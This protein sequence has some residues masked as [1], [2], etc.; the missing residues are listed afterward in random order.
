MRGG[1][2]LT[3]GPQT[4]I[5]VLDRA[6]AA[7]PHGVALVAGGL[8]VSYAQYAHAAD[9]L[10]ADLAEHAGG[11]VALVLRNSLA[12]PIA[13]MACARAGAIAMPLNPDY[14]AHELAPIFADA[15]PP[16]ILADADIVPTVAAAAGP[17]TRVRPV[18]PACI[19]ASFDEPAPTRLPPSPDP[20]ATGLLMFTGGTTGRPKGV[21]LSHRATAINMAQFA[22]RVGGRAD[23]VIA[24]AMPLYHA[25]GMAIGVHFAA[26]HAATLVILPRYRPDWLLDAVE[27][28]RA[29][30]LPAGP[31]IFQSLLGYAGLTRERVTS[32][33]LCLSG[34]AP[35][36]A[37]T[38]SRWEELT[39]APIYEGYGMTEAGPCLAFNGPGLPRKLGGTGTA[40]P[41]TEIA[42]VDPATR[43]PL[44]V[45]TQGEVR[46]R[47][48]QLMQ[49]YWHRA[50]ETAAA[51]DADGWLYT[52]DIGRI[53]SDGQLFIEDRLKDMVIVG[54]YNVYP[55]EVDEV[56][57]THPHVAE[58][59][60]VGA[61]CA[62]KGE[63]II[64]FAAP[65]D[66]QAL[67]A[68]A[69][70]A[71]CEARLVRYKRPAEYR[72]VERLPRTPVNKV[73]KPALR[74]L[75]RQGG[76]TAA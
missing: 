38:L 32:V 10:A 44:P 14:T 23:D 37:A 17:G 36:S 49:G 58:A 74:A 67:T 2:D 66:G 34:S 24:M 54:G 55:R 26:F 5:A 42:I 41:Q 52:G 19:T 35:L 50:E 12:M 63:R 25:F 9:V 45:G 59:A 73:D 6:V 47:G 30:I 21:M 53:D 70:A 7:N 1:A 65:R 8:R 60:A 76:T 11:P 57:C 39:A 40:L 69:L 33:R 22:E 16:L 61:P 71:H 75:A 51:L 68:E 18:T 29:T 20:D 48:P 72:I 31:A 46:A 15:H 62:A 13:L 43:A 4:P 56:L 3:G 28:E 64:A 27:A